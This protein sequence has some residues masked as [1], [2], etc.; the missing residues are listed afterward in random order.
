MPHKTRTEKTKTLQIAGVS[1][2]DISR[3]VLIKKSLSDVP[4]WMV[5]QRLLNEWEKDCGGDNA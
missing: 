5:F 1:E 2:M 4:F 3:F